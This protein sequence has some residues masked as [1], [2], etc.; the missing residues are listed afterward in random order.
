MKKAVLPFLIVV[1]CNTF[2]A[3]PARAQQ[4]SGPTVVQT[5]TNPLDIAPKDVLTGQIDNQAVEPLPSSVHPQA[6]PEYD[7]GPVPLD[8]PIS[9][10]T[11][12]LRRG[13]AQQAAL[14]ALVAGQQDPKSA[15]YRKWL[16]P[17]GFGS[18]F[19]LSQNDLNKIAAWLKQNGLVV[20]EVPK[21]RW[22]IIFS[23]T[24]GQVQSTFRTEIHY[25][26]INGTR[27]RANSS[28]LQIPRALAPVV[29]GILGIHDFRPVP[30]AR[31]E[32]AP[33]FGDGSTGPHYLFPS[34]YAAIYD[35]NP[36]YSNGIDGSG[37]TI[38]IV[39]DCNIDT[40]VTQTF[41]TLTGL[42]PNDVSVT[43]VGEAPAPCTG[44]A[45]AEPYLDVEW[46]GAV[47]RNAQIVL[48]VGTNIG[49]AA[50]YIVDNDLA[51][52]IST[53]FGYCEADGLGGENQ[54][55]LN[56]W[57]QAS[58]SGITSLVS[59]GDSGAAGCDDPSSSVAQFG[60]SVNG[61]C[62]TP[63]DICV[64]GTE[65]NDVSNPAQ[66]W[67]T[68]GFASGYIPEEAWNESGS[69]GGSDLWAS[70]GGYSTLYPI[71]TAPWQTG[72]S[73]AWRGVPDVSLTAA[74]HDGYF[75]C[76]DSGCNLSM[77]YIESGTSTSS[78]SFAG[79]MALVVEY[80]G[81]RQGAAHPLLYALASR[82]DIFHD[83]VVGNNSV[84]G[85]A[86]YS[87]AI[88]WDPVTGL[89]SVDANSMVTNWGLTS[90]DS[91]AVFLSSSSI[92]FGNQLIGS[93]SSSQTVT[94]TN[95]GNGQLN[96]S[97]IALQ[98]ANS[99]DFPTTTTCQHPATLAKGQNCV[100]TVTFEP[101]AAGV[102]TAS[103]AISDNAPESPQTV[104]LSGNGTSAAVAPPTVLQALTSS[105]SGVA[106][107]KCS[108]PP[109]V[110]SFS[111]A[112]P[113]AWVYF[114]LNGVNI[115]D[116]AAILFIQPNGVVYKT[117][118]SNSNLSGNVC[119]NADMDIAGYSPAS[120]PGTWTIQTFW[121]HSATP[122]LSLNFIIGSATAGPA[123]GVLP[124][125]AE[126]GA[127]VTDFY[128]VNRGSAL[129]SFSISFF[130]DNGSPSAVPYS[131]APVTILSGTAPAGGAKFYEVGTP[132]GVPESGS[133]AI[134]ADPSSTIQALFRRRGSDGSY[135][136][137]AIPA[138]TGSNEV[139]VPFDATTFS[140][141]GSQIYTGLA[142][143]NLD[144]S[145][146]ANLSCV[147][148]DSAGNVIPNAISAPVLNPLGHWANYLFPALTGL[149]G[150]L[151]CTSN[152]QIGAIGIRALG[153]NALSSLPVITLP[154]SASLGTK[155]LPQFAVG[156][157]FVTDFYV[158]NSGGSKANFS[159]SFY[160]DQG[161]PVALPFADG[162]G[163]LSTLSG[164]I[165]AGG[166]GFYEAGTPQGAAQSGSAVIASDSA[167][168]IQALFRRQ[169]GGSY[170]E[171]A[172][173]AT[174]GSNEI[175]LPFDATTFSG[176]G[177]RIY[178]GLA[179]ANLDT[180]N[181]ANLVCT[182]RDS[183]GNII[184][185]AISAPTLNPLGHWAAYLFPALT[186]LRGTLDCTS[187]TP[188]GAIGIRALGT[189]AIS[190]LP[191]ISL[192]N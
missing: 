78:P 66:F 189:N 143:A 144:A 167:I 135:Y 160:D 166:A 179:I 188:I 47:A 49:D 36:L 107:G 92:T 131:S 13:S 137:A 72:N 153:T 40:S 70:G 20:N 35:L 3:L 147:A 98:G 83:I 55:W 51:P 85:Q 192:P 124:Q 25:Y 43:V 60:L 158:V 132:Q 169:A 58:S 156:A 113:S 133:A 65:F 99:A 91:P 57:E 168:T 155:V 22:T 41:R 111:A 106:N 148:R 146:S 29:V 180:S 117:L 182:A 139:Q 162:L 154:L 142:I 54:Y 30:V 151:D 149:R 50:S 84:P 2:V 187:N 101:S 172:V 123:T 16:T 19:G 56:L 126:G 104:S 191:V 100:L 64:G 76:Q 94:M 121:N 8:L 120:D 177:D 42:P 127:F 138:A 134:S 185:N 37:Q 14:D 102:R 44:N 33:R 190:S 114:N 110:T 103:I 128:V 18:H 48:V 45:L 112:S 159:I 176:N 11:L 79:M 87:A 183:L 32:S 161:N 17:D 186:G 27:H 62:S 181:P 150:T 86:G 163:N 140:G 108:T 5:A 164:S 116:S 175:L 26:D 10:M 165:P 125:F 109:Q 95:N 141:N 118:T 171:A 184:T 178:T 34:D 119:F 136:E 1:S 74:S 170:Y 38:A 90:T 88:G 71:S 39:G 130:A 6:R 59:S 77:F 63:Y 157:S 93:M 129:G 89:G 96:I 69:N 122:L 31:T 4:L 152:T 105:A 53:S 24:A 67:S 73:S 82:A 81:N 7:A 12:V 115:G 61:I 15:E 9:R 28:P 75:I 23:G 174:A 68:Q 80:T 97:A 173:P 46:S 52:V 21:G 145:K